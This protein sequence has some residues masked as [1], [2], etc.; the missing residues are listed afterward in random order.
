[1]NYVD[2]ISCPLILFQGLEDKIVPP[3]Q[4]QMIFDAVKK[5][6]VPCAFVAFPG[7]QH[8]F[9]R[10]ENIRRSFD[11]ELYFYSKVFG[12]ELAEKVEP[13]KI[14]NLKGAKRQAASVKQKATSR[15]RKAARSKRKAVKAKQKPAGKKRKSVKRKAKTR[16]TRK[17]TKKQSRVTSR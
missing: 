17:S 2:R 7:E 3:N 8:G 9:R 14:E 6:G 1:M 12:F 13:V 5:K 15:K 10:A 16:K 4:S 11:G